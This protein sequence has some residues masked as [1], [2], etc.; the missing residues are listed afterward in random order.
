MEKVKV[1]QDFLYSYIQEHDINRSTIAALMGMDRSMINSCF[2]HHLDKYGKPRFFSANAIQKM[3]TAL[4]Q[5]ADE[6]R[7]SVITFGSPQ[8]YTNRGGT[9]DPACMPA[10]KALSRFFNLTAMTARVLGWTETKKN[11]VLSAPSSKI[12]GHITQ[13]DINRLNAE[14]LAV[15]GTLS[16][17]EVEPSESA[18]SSS[19]D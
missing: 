10:V 3:N 19:S 1:S 6:M 4:A 17:I 18:A 12:Y 8:T 15:A 2:K 7:G 14:L 16:G 5:M 13:D 9:F 11:T